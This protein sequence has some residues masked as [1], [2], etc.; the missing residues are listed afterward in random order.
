MQ[1]ELKCIPAID[2]A[3]C[4]HRKGVAVSNWIDN[5]KAISIDTMPQIDQNDE[6]Q[7]HSVN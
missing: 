7:A 3:D 1:S 5:S 4:K 2:N 6:N